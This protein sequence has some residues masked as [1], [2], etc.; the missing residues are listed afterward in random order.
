[1]TQTVFLVED[2]ADLLHVTAA[3]LEQ[4]GMRVV[5]ARNGRDALARMREHAG[6]AARVAVI[7]VHLP[8][9]DGAELMEHMR[10]DAALALIPVIVAAGGETSAPGA[11]FTVRKPYEMEELVRLIRL[12]A[13][14]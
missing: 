8:L 2:D 4:S 13:N 6:A 1:V 7:D 12:A 11:R 9:M 10:G 5:T 3:L 14:A